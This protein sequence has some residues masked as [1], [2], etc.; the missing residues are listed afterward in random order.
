MEVIGARPGF[1]VEQ[2]SLT[3]GKKRCEGERM[4]RRM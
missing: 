1:D 2:I 3:A 4:K